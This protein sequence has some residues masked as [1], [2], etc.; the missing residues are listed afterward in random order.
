[1]MKWQNSLT[2]LGFSMNHNS[3]GGGDS[4]NNNKRRSSMSHNKSIT[5]FSDFNDKEQEVLERASDGSDRSLDVPLLFPL[6]MESDDG[7]DN[8][9]RSSKNCHQFFFS[10]RATFRD[11]DEEDAEVE[12]SHSLEITTDYV[13]FTDSEEEELKKESEEQ[14]VGGETPTTSVVKEVGNEASEKSSHID[15]AAAETTVSRTTEFATQDEIVDQQL[16]TS[17]MNQGKVNAILLRNKMA[18]VRGLPM[19]AINLNDLKYNDDVG[20]EQGEQRERE[21]RDLYFE[22]QYEEWRMQG[23]NAALALFSFSFVGGG[24]GSKNDAEQKQSSTPTSAKVEEDDEMYKKQKQEEEEECQLQ[25]EQQQ[26][27]SAEAWR[28]VGRNAAQSMLRIIRV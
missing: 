5:L 17:S 25:Q 13:A 23:R 20:D 19:P 12:T 9:T 7:E 26:Q 14:P 22:Q 15:K 21:Q 28:M 24:G 3:F 27:R 10:A 4:N 8:Q 1:M 11:G 18:Q 6:D 16:T 2:Q